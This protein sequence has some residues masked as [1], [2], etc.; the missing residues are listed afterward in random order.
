MRR[1]AITD[2]FFLMN[3]TRQTPMHVGG[4]NLFTLPEG[5][6]E[7]EFLQHLGEVLRYDGELRRPLGERLKLG[8][9]GVAGPIH[10]ERDDQLD[11]EYHVRHSALPKPGRYRELFAW[12]RGC[13]APCSIAIARCG[14]CT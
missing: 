11:M 7:Q 4:I 12:S 10:W 8:P 5:T 13:T 3:E 9:L 6:D 2:A 1:M 14:K